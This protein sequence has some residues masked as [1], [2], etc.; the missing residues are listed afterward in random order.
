LTKIHL[1]SRMINNVI[2]QEADKKYCFVI[3]TT[4]KS[5]EVLGRHAECFYGHIA[6]VTNLWK[7]ELFDLAKKLKIPKKIIKRKAGCPELWDTEA[8]GVNWYALDPI[9][10]LMYDKKWSPE[11]ISKKYKIDNVWLNKIKNRIDKQ[12]KRTKTKKL[13]L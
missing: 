8:L 4:D 1:R 7:T 2:F 6:P 9:L 3:D 5:E 10:F 12:P 13:Y 11:R